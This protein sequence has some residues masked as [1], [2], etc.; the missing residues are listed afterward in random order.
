ME[1]SNSLHNF[2]KVR[3]LIVD[4]SVLMRQMISNILSRDPDID[5]VGVACDPFIARELIKSLNPDV[6]TLDI[7]MPKM[8]GLSFLGK[9]MTLRPMPVVMVSTLTEKGAKETL[10]ALEIGA[11]DYVTKPSSNVKENFEKIAHNLCLKVKTA[12]KARIKN[13][14]A[15]KI[16]NPDLV[17]EGNTL[18]Q[19]VGIGSSTGGVEALTE[20]FLS[21]PSSCPPVVVVQHMPA[22]F[23]ASFA[24]RLNK[25][26]N[27]TIQEV[28]QDMP[29]DKGNVYIAPGDKHFCIKHRGHSFIAELH[30]GETVNSHKPSVDVLFSSIAKL[31]LSNVCG[32]LLTG[33]GRDGAEGLLQMRHSGAKTFGQNEET[34]LI[35][36]MPRVAKEIGAVQK[37]IPLKKVASVIMGHI[38][39]TV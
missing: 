14:L 21:L 35:Y 2:Q 1:T 10:Q 38:S 33:M 30:D 7:N 28:K 34:C 15:A 20:V 4:D 37:E 8:D 36:G 24:A 31:T 17:I 25:Q 18:P 39:A 5:V 9:I 12:A 22:G 6:V 27:P 29:I 3:V 19:L 23:T 16:N 11:V 13:R 32:I 26:C